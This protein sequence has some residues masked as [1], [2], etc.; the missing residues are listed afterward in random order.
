MPVVTQG[1]A[2]EDQDGVPDQAAE[3]GEG[4]ERQQRHPVDAG[5]DGDQRAYARD[6]P[7]DQDGDRS[8]PGEPVDGRVDVVSVDQRH[9]LGDPAQPVGPDG[10]A[11]PVEQA[12]TGQGTGGG[13]QDGGDDTVRGVGAG[14]GEAGQ[15]QDHLTGDRREDVL[16][17]DGQEDSRPADGLHQ[18]GDPV[19]DRVDPTHGVMTSVCSVRCAGPGGPGA[20]RQ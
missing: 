13:P 16:Q 8:V 9:P 7:A 6:Q 5:R 14:R 17:Q 10:S 20:V 11:E 2:G 3:R 15:R 19:D 12:R 4:A 18:G 1:V